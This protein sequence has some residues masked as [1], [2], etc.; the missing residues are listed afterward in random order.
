MNKHPRDMAAQ[1]CDFVLSDLLSAHCHNVTF[2]ISDHERV[3]SKNIPQKDTESEQL[4]TEVRA[5]DKRAIRYNIRN[6][7]R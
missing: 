7:I 2:E 3:R 1:A 6:E 5:T 4:L